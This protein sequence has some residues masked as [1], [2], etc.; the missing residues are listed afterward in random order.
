MLTCYISKITD[1]QFLGPEEHKGVLMSSEEQGPL[2]SE[3]GLS[4]SA[5]P[6][7]SSLTQ[8]LRAFNYFQL[9]FKL[10]DMLN[11]QTHVM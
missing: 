11:H 6:F 9:D 3:P 8:K 1:F 2:A 5:C 4:G 10:N 7:T